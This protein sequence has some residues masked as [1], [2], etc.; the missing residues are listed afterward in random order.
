MKKIFFLVFCCFFISHDLCGQIVSQGLRGDCVRRRL[1]LDLGSSNTKLK[2]ADVD[3]CHEQVGKRV[4]ES[5]LEIPLQSYLKKQGQSFFIADAD[6]Q[7]VATQLEH[8]VSTVAHKYAPD[9]MVGVATEAVRKMSNSADFL[10]LLSGKLGFPVRL[11]S[12]AQEGEFS[13]VS[14][15]SDPRFFNQDHRSLVVWSIGALSSSFTTKTKRLQ[16]LSHKNEVGAEEFHEML[17]RQFKGTSK[18]LLFPLQKRFINDAIRVAKDEIAVKLLKDA[19]VVDRL[20][21]KKAK[22]VGVGRAHALSVRSYANPNQ[23]GGYTKAQL[24]TAIDRLSQ[25]T[26]Q[27]IPLQKQKILS[28]VLSN[29]ILVC[30]VLEALGID[31]VL[32]VE[33]QEVADGVLMSSKNWE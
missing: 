7:K 10:K 18:G 12:E 16:F 15:V 17:L 19:A 9:E 8:F 25:T 22:L 32:V 29:M 24:L 11:I 30:G 3:V 1:V 28:L 13:F 2:V 23:P 21:N 27:N 33:S 26:V 6:M 20:L 5:V 14:A 4:H 31:E